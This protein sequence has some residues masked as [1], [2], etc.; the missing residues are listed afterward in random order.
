M[1]KQDIIYHWGEDHL[2]I[3]LGNRVETRIKIL[4]LAELLLTSG[5]ATVFL[6]QS[7]PITQSPSH[8]V[9]C[10]GATLLYL[11]ASYRFLSR[12]FFKEQ[13]LLTRQYIA[14]VHRTL[15][16]KHERR[17]GWAGIGPLHYSGKA[18][19]TDHP[20]KG[21]SFDYFGF[22]THE[23]FIQTLHHEGN[24]F[25]YY[26]DVRI[27]FARNVYS[28]DAEEMVHIMKLYAGASL[29]L[30]PEWEEMLQAQELDDF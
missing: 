5:M 23:H 26:D 20:L 18:A 25:F 27:N 29:R 13:L 8:L 4:F 7:L 16:V 6:F 30:G 24:L 17:Y 22:E 14:I 9:A 28:W 15:F 19:K 1:T 2:L 21:K 10:I 11:L 3:T 12:I